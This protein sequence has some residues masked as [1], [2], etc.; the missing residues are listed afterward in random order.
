MQYRYQSTH[1]TSPFYYSY[2]NVSLGFANSSFSSFFL[3]LKLEFQGPPTRV[4]I[5]NFSAFS[6]FSADK[7][8]LCRDSSSLSFS[9]VN[10]NRKTRFLCLKCLP[11]KYGNTFKNQSKMI[12]PSVIFVG[13]TTS[14]ITHLKSPHKIIL[15]RKSSES[16]D[17]KPKV[18]DA[19]MF[20]RQY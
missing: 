1:Y 12:L 14:L 3:K 17:I 8:L 16:E 18:M 19:M 9:F 4:Y 13:T 5:L 15:K 11:L 7:A 20:L 6:C 10:N 2:S